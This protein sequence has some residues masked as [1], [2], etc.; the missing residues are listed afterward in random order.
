MTISPTKTLAH[1]HV[2]NAAHAISRRLLKPDEKLCYIGESPL[3]DALTENLALSAILL[4]MSALAWKEFGG[5][6]GAFF[7][8]WFGANLSRTPSALA[9]ALAAFFLLF[10]SLPVA[11]ALGF[12]S[13]ARR[14]TTR[15]VM[16][17][18]R[19]LLIFEVETDPRAEPHVEDLPLSE[20]RSSTAA[21]KSDGR[22]RWTVNAHWPRSDTSETTGRRFFV[23]AGAQ[24]AAAKLDTLLA[25]RTESLSA[26]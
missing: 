25:R 18:D 9:L 16:L 20:I 3:R 11:A 17:T 13:R 14:K 7:D 10:L 6:L 5:A 15:A 12:L 24:E 19:R 2:S 1:A 23:K 4:G 8:A 22:E 26:S 21:R